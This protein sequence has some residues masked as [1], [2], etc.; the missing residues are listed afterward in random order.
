MGNSLSIT[1]IG[2]KDVFEV[3]G[4]R[5]AV[6]GSAI[7]QPGQNVVQQLTADII[8]SC[9]AG[10]QP[11]QDLAL[12]LTPPQLQVAVQDFLNGM[13]PQLANARQGIEMM[14]VLELREPNFFYARLAVSFVRRATGATDVNWNGLVAAAQVKTV[15]R[16]QNRHERSGGFVNIDN[17]RQDNH[18][19]DIA[20]GA[21]PAQLAQIRGLLEAAHDIVGG[22]EHFDVV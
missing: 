9:N 21:T 4:A 17:Y 7:L 2:R 10:D 19:K 8:N 22:I 3:K 6:N 13:A 12:T 1:E 11:R 15:T 5:K 14:E 18:F 16:I 20:R